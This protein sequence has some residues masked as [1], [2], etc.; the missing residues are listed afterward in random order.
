MPL[1]E[2]ADEQSSDETRNLT[3]NEG[4]ESGTVV[5][6]HREGPQRSSACTLEADDAGG[7][8]CL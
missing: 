7:E 5:H 8:R 4:A 2:C 6:I 3:E 1:D